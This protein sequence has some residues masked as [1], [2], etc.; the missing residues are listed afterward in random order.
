M[1]LQKQTTPY[2]RIFKLVTG[3]EIITKVTGEDDKNY[4]IDKPLQ[5]GMGQRGFQFAPVVI[6]MD[7]DRPLEL[8]K[9]KII[10]QGPPV[11]EIESQYESMTTGIALPTKSS[12]IKA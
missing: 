12:I 11:A 6:M 3:E 2:I 5:M 8:P 1:L 4:T 9:D 10:L 7:P